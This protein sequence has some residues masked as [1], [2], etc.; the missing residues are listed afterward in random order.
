MSINVL[1]VSNLIL[2]T[3]YKGTAAAGQEIVAIDSLPNDPNPF[4]NYEYDSTSNSLVQR[5]A[6]LTHTA[7]YKMASADPSTWNDIIA[8]DAAQ[9]AYAAAIAAG[10][11]IVSTATPALNGTYSIT[12]TSEIKIIGASTRIMKYG[13]FPGG[14]SSLTWL[15]INNAPHTFTNITDFMNFA[16]AVATYISELNAALGAG[17]AGGAWVAPALPITIP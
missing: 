4:L 3:G 13:A 17:L 8:A 9:T 5:T 1:V 6:P 11:Q 7:Y 10:C 14:A 2:A 15:D 16:D 12:E